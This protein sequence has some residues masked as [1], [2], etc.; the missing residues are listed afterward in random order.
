MQEF[1][2]QFP[3][4]FLCDVLGEKSVLYIKE[5][6]DDKTC[7]HGMSNLDPKADHPIDCNQLLY[8]QKSWYMQDGERY[9]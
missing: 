5:L 8:K 3:F 1:S 9:T 2:T 6:I 4:T 7:T